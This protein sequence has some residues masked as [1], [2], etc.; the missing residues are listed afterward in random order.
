MSRS[1]SG[2]I[3]RNIVNYL[4]IFHLL[5]EVALIDVLSSSSCCCISRSSN[6]N[7]LL[8]M[9]FLLVIVVVVVGVVSIKF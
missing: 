7:Y 1:R 3:I 5:V 8:L 2:G 4:S 9:L 6:V